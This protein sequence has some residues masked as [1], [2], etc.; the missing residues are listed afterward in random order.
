MCQFGHYLLTCRFV[1]E[2]ISMTHIF[3]H[4][5]I[6][7]CL[8][9][10]SWLNQYCVIWEILFTDETLVFMCVGFLGQIFLFPEVLKF[11]TA[12]LGWQ[13]LCFLGVPWGPPT[14]GASLGQLC[15]H[16]LRHLL[17]MELISSFPD[18][19]FFW[20]H[21]ASCNLLWRCVWKVIFLVRY[22]SENVCVS[23]NF[24]IAWWA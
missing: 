17:E 19:F 21:T 7:T 11:P 23:L 18:F 1:G 9:H 3:L 13:F 10:N 15:H 20:W 24:C 2:D 14:S 6:S 5:Q 4:L 16:H 8:Y 12:S 22:T